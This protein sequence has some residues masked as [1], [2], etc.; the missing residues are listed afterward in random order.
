MTLPETLAALGM[1]PP[2]YI[3]L[4]RFMRFPGC[5][6][7]RGN[8]AGWCRLIM[9]TLAVYG[10]WSAGLSAVWTDDRHIDSAEA[11]RMLKEARERERR[12]ARERAA[13]QAQVSR[14]A[15][16]LIASAKIGSHAYLLSKGFP[17]E[18]GLISDG[19]LVIP[20]RDVDDYFNILSA[21]L[22]FITGYDGEGAN[23]KPIFE[24]KF[25]PGGRAMG[26]IY[27]MGALLAQGVR[28]VLCEGYATGLSLHAAMARLPGKAT[29]V[30]CFSANNLERVSTYFPNAIVA[31]DNDLPNK[32]TGE[33]AGEAAAIRTGL[34]WVMPDEP[35]TD[36]NDTHQ[37]DG[38]HAVVEKLRC[39]F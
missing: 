25:L 15:R 19:R 16:Q 20:M 28:V 21:Q 1:T 34:K 38:I 3:A 18:S 36:F 37:K 23:R 31:A 9:P 35:G 14:E 13:K 10:D 11:Q 33:K 12:M 4:G 7:G 2:K 39:A 22:I 24:K 30:C 5:G 29:I 32:M 6:K 17:E 26:A 8:T 27:R